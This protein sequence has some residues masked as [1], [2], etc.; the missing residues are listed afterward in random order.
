MLGPCCREGLSLVVESGG[1]SL[2]VKSGGLSLVV[3]SGGYSLV[4]ESGG[5]SL[6]GASK[7]SS[8]GSQALEHRFNRCGTQA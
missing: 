8:C 4:V 6:V 3:E 5:Y 2:V 7:L 1:L